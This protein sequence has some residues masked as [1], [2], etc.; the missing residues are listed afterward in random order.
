M[1]NLKTK[2]KRSKII[3]IKTCSVPISFD[4]TCEAVANVHMVGTGDTIEYIRCDECK[5]DACNLSG[6]KID[7]GASL[8]GAMLFYLYVTNKSYT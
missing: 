7:P 1:H 4:N 5:A 6:S 3:V 2:T 8:V